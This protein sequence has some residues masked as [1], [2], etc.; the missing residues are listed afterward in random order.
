MNTINFTY[1][2]LHIIRKFFALTK[3]E[4]SG[5]RTIHLLRHTYVFCEAV[6]LDEDDG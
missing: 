2:V 4:R 3:K 6:E 1:Y 5:F